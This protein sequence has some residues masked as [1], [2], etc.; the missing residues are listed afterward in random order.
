MLPEKGSSK[1]KVQR[2]YQLFVL[3]KKLIALS[4]KTKHAELP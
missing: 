3:C 4:T 1:Q 2:Q